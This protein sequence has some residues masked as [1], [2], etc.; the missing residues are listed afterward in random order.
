MPG[1]IRADKNEEILTEDARL[2]RLWGLTLSVGKKGLEGQRGVLRGLHGE[3]GRKSDGSHFRRKPQSGSGPS[4][5]LCYLESGQVRPISKQPRGQMSMGGK[6]RKVFIIIQRRFNTGKNK[7]L[8]SLSTGA[9]GVKY[10]L[11]LTLM[12]GLGCCH[13]LLEDRGRGRRSGGQKMLKLGQKMFS[14]ETN[15]AQR[16]H[17]DSLLLRGESKKKRCDVTPGGKNR[18]V[19]K[20]RRKENPRT[21]RLERKITCSR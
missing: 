18:L 16:R 14:F 21:I 8:R 9:L 1:G 4:P 19:V 5:S 6:K 17:Q 11:L 12:I 10:L 20:T 13:E 3:M 2:G 15:C 7:V